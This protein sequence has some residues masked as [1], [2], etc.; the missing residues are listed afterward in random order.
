MSQLQ[1][2]WPSVK[3]LLPTYLVAGFKTGMNANMCE[4]LAEAYEV[5]EGRDL[6]FS[7]SWSPEIKAISFPE[8]ISCSLRIDTYEYLK[9]AAK[10][11]Q[12]VDRPIETVI[13]GHI[14]M[15]RS[16]EGISGNQQSFERMITMLWE[17]EKNV[18]VKIRVPLS[19]TEYRLACDAHKDGRKISIKGFPIKEGKYWHLEKPSNF[20]VLLQ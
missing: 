6:H 10:E 2:T 13:S 11:L 5:L 16:E 14:I 4:K 18:E 3:I 1:L 20:V 17:V 12:R 19:T 7:L 8:G 15:L 9:E